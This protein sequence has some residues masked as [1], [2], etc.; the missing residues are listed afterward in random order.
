MPYRGPGKPVDVSTAEDPTTAAT[1]AFVYCVRTGTA[2]I[3]D[4]KVGLG[5]ALAV[6]QANESLRQRKEVPI[7]PQ[8]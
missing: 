8:L 1:R 3:A 5:S 4:A 2:P 7:P 6:I